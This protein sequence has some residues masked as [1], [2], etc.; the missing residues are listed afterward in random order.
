MHWNFGDLLDGCAEVL[1]GDAPALIHGQRVVSWGEFARRSNNVAAR[2]RALGAEPGDKVAI[3]LR[4]CPEYMETLAAC[5]KARLVPVNVNFRY[6]DDELAYIFGDSDARFSVFAEEFADRVATLRERHPG[7]SWAQVGGEPPPFALG[8]EALAEQGNGAPLG[9]ERSPDDL[10]FIYTGGTTGM[11]KAVMWR[12]GDLWGALGYG[13]NA[14]ANAGS[15]PGTP[16]QHIENI[17]RFGPGAKQLIVCPLMHG[18]GLLTAIANISGGGCCITLES[19]HFDV[20]ELWKAVERTRAQSLIIVGDAFA[21]PMLRSLDENPGKW[22]ISSLRVIISSGVMWSREVKLGLLEHHAGM[23]LAD[24][25]GSSE[26]VGFGS[27]I[28]SAA[29]ETKTARFQIG[30]RCKVFTEDHREVVPGSGEKGFIA[31]CG[32][33]PLGYYKDAQKTRKT[34]PTIDGVRYAIPGDWCTVEADGTLNLLGRGNACINTAGEKVHPEEVEEALKTHADVDDA[35][36][37]GL[38]DEKW[39]QAVTAV[40][41]LRDGARLDET[42]LRDFVRSKLAGYKTPKRIVQVETMFRAPNGKADYKSAAAYVE[43][44]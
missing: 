26:A 16:E 11:P 13:A 21:R 29:G 5:F 33:I 38:A 19:P 17:G 12:A 4:N 40:V 6:R 18:T 3:Y 20:E 44:L 37:F 9:I 22:D 1:P 43:N 2:L 25:F 8:Y 7:M 30:E 34:F 31:R 36:V 24:M 27:S 10:L 39:G 28:T 32:P 41:T 15:R 14:P 23:F 35:L 42:A